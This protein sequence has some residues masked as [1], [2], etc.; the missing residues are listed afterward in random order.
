MAKARMKTLPKDFELLLEKGT[1]AELKAVFD[2]CEIDA[3]GGYSKQT[4]L[5]FDKCPD[6]LVRWLVALGADL[7]ATDTWGNTPLHHRVRSRR[8]SIEVLLE[9]GADVNSASSSIGTPLH[10]AADSHNA[11]HAR[12]LLQHGARANERNK[13]QLTPLELALR[14][15]NNIDIENM[16]MLAKVLLDAGAEKT[17]RMK[18]FVEEIGKRF[19][20][21]RRGFAPECVDA[22]S[23]AL[24]ELYE[25]FD[26]LPVPRRQIHDGNSPVVVKAKTWQTQHQELWNLLVPPKGPAATVQGE[27]IRISGRI[28]HELD[29]NGGA[30]WDAD[31]KTMADAFLDHV[32]SGKPL[33]PPDLAEAAAIVAEVKRNSGDTARM[34]E[35]AVSWVM[36]NLDPVELKPP[37]YRR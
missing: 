35:L 20:F 26:V 29:G 9:L 2:I 32:Q 27:V 5:A 28:S 6:D 10:A 12:L 11:A 4:A 1:M 37:S 15:C 25:I 31:Y 24:D 33:S 36:Q 21:H 17:P 8:S 3:R 13:E 19:E 23:R 7:S 34:A 14:G 30:N 22:V 16:V 18:G